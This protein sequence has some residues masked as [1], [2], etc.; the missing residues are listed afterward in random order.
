M[1]TIQPEKKKIGVGFGVM[2]VRDGKVLFGRRHSDPAK[3]DSELHGEG[4]WT[5]PGGKLEFGES[6]EEGARRE[7]KEETGMDLGSA[8]VICVN[9][10]KVSDAH[11]VTIGLF[12]EDFAGDP[13]V[14][15]PDEIVE[16]QWF[17][18]DAPPSPLFFPSAEILNNRKKG[19]FYVI[20]KQ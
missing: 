2:M 18:L 15:E 3:A 1:E 13:K 17:G 16:W 8:E 4:S 11:F 10:D 14:M 19:L 5:M 20:S 7:V 9:N 6:F 12:S